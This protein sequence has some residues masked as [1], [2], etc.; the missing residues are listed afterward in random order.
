[1]NTTI[2]EAEIK[3]PNHDKYITTTEFNKLTAEN[4]SGRLKKGNLVI[5]NDFDNKLT[6]VNKQFFSN[7]TKHLEV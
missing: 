1:M 5:K 4:F 6:S 2:S 7:K 3:I